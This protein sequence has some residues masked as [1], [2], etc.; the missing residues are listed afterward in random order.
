MMPSDKIG[1]FRLLTGTL[2]HDHL[3]KVIA[4]TGVPFMEEVNVTL[5]LPRGWSGRADW[6]FWNQEAAAF[7]LKDLKTIRGEGLRYILQDGA[8]EEHIWQGSAYYWGLETMGIPL[9]DKFSVCY[10]P[11][12]NDYR[13]PLTA[14]YSEQVIKPLPK[15]QVFQRMID[16]R[17]DVDAYLASLPVDP[18]PSHGQRKLTDYLTDALADPLA[19]VQKRYKLKDGTTDVKL[20]P[21]WLT[22]FCPYPDI[23]CD[24]SNQGTTKI[25]HFDSKGEYH[26][27]KGFEQYTV[28]T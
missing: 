3:H 12:N 26:A 18:V 24:C 2:W 20:V 22:A 14:P 10:I 17:K 21:H 25:G 5:G 19:R 13:N 23:L 16:L 4:S 27:R 9:T 15:Q 1:G 11:M 8:K 7:E 6:L 28:S